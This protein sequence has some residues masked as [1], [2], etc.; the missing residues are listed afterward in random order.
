MLT[1]LYVEITS[2]W[3]SRRVLPDERGAQTVEWLA[4]GGAIA[5]ILAAV[6][7]LNQDIGAAIAGAIKKLFG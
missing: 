3:A 2:R 7:A 5:A 6:A 4:L 1:K